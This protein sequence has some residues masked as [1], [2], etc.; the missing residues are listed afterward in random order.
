MAPASIALASLDRKAD[1]AAI[2]ALARRHG[3]QTYFYAAT[4]LARVPGIARPSQVVER[5]VG[6][7]GVAEPAAL[8]AAQAERLLIEKQVVTST[9]SQTHDLCP[10]PVRRVSRASWRSGQ[11]HLHWRWPR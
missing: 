8:R 7:P 1:E 5:C 9:L 2:L 11:G 6:T 3:W 4:E 10:G